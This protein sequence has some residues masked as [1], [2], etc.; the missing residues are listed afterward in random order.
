MTRRIGRWI[1]NSES[2]LYGEAGWHL[3]GS[4]IV[5]DFM[6]GADPDER[7]RGIYLGYNWPGVDDGWYVSRYCRD[8]M[9]RVEKQWD[10]FLFATLAGD[11]QAQRHAAWLAGAWPLKSAAK[12][13]HAP[14]LRGNRKEPGHGRWALPVRFAIRLGA[15]VHSSGSRFGP[16]LP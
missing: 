10:E 13:T 3:K 6:L 9:S 4:P 12:A 8:S 15:E 2:T 1:Y 5:I 14:A 7:G 16:P 11:K